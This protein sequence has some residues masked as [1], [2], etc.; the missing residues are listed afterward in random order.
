MH[1][2]WIQSPENQNILTTVKTSILQAKYFNTANMSQL[3]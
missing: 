3:Q 1:I 2:S